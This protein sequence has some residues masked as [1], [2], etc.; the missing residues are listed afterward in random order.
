MYPHGWGGGGGG[1][2]EKPLMGLARCLLGGRGAAVYGPPG[3]LVRAR[4]PLSFPGWQ[5]SAPTSPDP[6]LLPT[7]STNSSENMFTMMNPIAPAG[8]RPNVSAP[9]APHG[10]GEPTGSQPWPATDNLPRT[11][12]PTCG[13]L[14]SFPTAPWGSED[15]APG[16]M[17]AGD[18]LLSP[19]SGLPGWLWGMGRCP[20]VGGAQLT[21]SA[22]PS[23]LLSVGY[24]WPR[25]CRPGTGGDTAP[26]PGPGGCGHWGLLSR[27]PSS[28]R[29]W[30]RARRALF[31]GQR[32]GCTQGCGAAWSWLHFPRARGCRLT[33][34][35]PVLQSSPSNM[36]GLSNPPGTPRDD[37]EMGGNFLHPFQ[38]DSYSPSMTMS[39]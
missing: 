22:L 4:P 5:L 3:E 18:Q 39:V 28:C 32:P 2:R 16:G 15:Q 6:T 1:G 26:L 14:P 38:S 25:F 35:L 21:G 13:P 36:A 23:R 27:A 20:V 34:C 10:Q 37:G 19:R 11:L 30:P 8:S 31:P 33:Q 29:G 17:R 7:D 12:V 24:A 9:A